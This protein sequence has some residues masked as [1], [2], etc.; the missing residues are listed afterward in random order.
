MK[1]GKQWLSI[2]ITSIMLISMIPLTGLA[3]AQTGA[4]APQK[5]AASSRQTVTVKEVQDLKEAVAAQQ[6]QIQQQNQLVDQ[7]RSQLQQ[8]LNATQQANAAAQKAAT[9]VDQA[10]ST[11]AQAQQSATQAKT[12]A[13]QAA[14]NA[15]L[16]G[17]MTL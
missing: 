8:L 5:R 3:S 15:A 14:S 9:G 4:P 7:L 11:A 12:V 17:P 2:S 13:D 6:Q 1:P 16:T 10:Q